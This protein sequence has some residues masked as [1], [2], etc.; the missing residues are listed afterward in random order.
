MFLPG[1][2]RRPPLPL[3][4][5]GTLRRPK[6]VKKKCLKTTVFSYLLKVSN[7]L[8]HLMRIG[9]LI[10]RNKATTDRKHLNSPIPVWAE[11]MKF[12][13]EDLR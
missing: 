6:G 13:D 4:P 1:D 2:L 5:P 9:R 10:H 3:S 7:D 8:A 11:N 12:F